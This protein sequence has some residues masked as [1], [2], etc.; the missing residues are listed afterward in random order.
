MNFHK[1]SFII[2]LLFFT[3]ILIFVSGGKLREA[4]LGKGKQKGDLGI[5]MNLQKQLSHC[6]WMMIVVVVMVMKEA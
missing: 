4:L 1:S 3:L 6:S 5:E 2:L